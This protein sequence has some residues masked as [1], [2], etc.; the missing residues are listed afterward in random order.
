MVMRIRQ[1]DKVRI[2]WWRGFMAIPDATGHRHR[3]TTRSLLPQRLHGVAGNK[4]TMKNAWCLLA[5]SMA[6]AMHRYDTKRIARWSGTRATPEAT[7]RCHLVSIATD[8]INRSRKSQFF[9]LL[10]CWKGGTGDVKTST[11]NRGMTYQ[12]DGKDLSNNMWYLNRCAKL[13]D[14]WNNNRFLI[15]IILPKSSVTNRKLVTVKNS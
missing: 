5:I 6:M 7:G 11:N 8:R 14:Y 15:S 1:N 9:I 10:T 2:S 13:V 4:K 3:A 12:T